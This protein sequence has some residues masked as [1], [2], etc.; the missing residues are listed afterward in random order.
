MK[1]TI[2]Q[3]E[4]MAGYLE[5]SLSSVTD[6]LQEAL[7]NYSA[8]IDDNMDKEDWEILDSLVVECPSCGWWTSADDLCESKDM[9]ELYCS[10]CYEKSE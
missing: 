1:L 3:I 5:G 8:T 10:N 4:Y 2:E 6:M 9:D 7:D